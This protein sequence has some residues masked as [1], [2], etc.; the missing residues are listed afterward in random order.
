MKGNPYL[1]IVVDNREPQDYIIKKEPEPLLR[2]LGGVKYSVYLKDGT[3]LYLAEPTL[4]EVID[5]LKRGYHVK[6]ITIA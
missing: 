5:R 2:R 3:P 1:G 6:S 4:Q